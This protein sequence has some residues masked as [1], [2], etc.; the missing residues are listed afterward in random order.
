M[1]SSTSGAVVV[2]DDLVLQ[3][4][5]HAGHDVVEVVAVDL[6]ELAVLERLQGLGRVAGEIAHD[7]HH[8]GELF[9]D[10]RALRLHIVG[11]VDPRLSHAFQLLVDTLSHNVISHSLLKANDI[12][13]PARRLP[14]G[15]ENPLRSK[16]MA[17]PG[18]ECRRA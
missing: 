13:L 1:A 8:E 10:H 12:L 14:A 17:S 3:A 7:P 11:D 5:R 4:G 9:L 6:D 16:S 15:K 18:A 2:V